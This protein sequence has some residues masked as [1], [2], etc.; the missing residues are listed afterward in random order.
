MSPEEEERKIAQRANEALGRALLKPCSDRILRSITGAKI[1]LF[2]Y[3]L[4]RRGIE[5]TV[6]ISEISAHLSLVLRNTYE[7]ARSV[8]SLGCG[9]YVSGYRNTH[10]VIFKPG[11]FKKEHIEEA[12]RVLN[13]E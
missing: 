3:N 6:T 7:P 5:K 8:A 4:S 9:R 2:L 10:I 1:Y 12:A 13:D 11:T